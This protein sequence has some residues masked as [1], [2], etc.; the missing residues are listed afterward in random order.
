MIAR[1]VKFRRE[2]NSKYEKGLYFEK[3]QLLLDAQENVM[4]TVYDIIDDITII[5]FSTMLL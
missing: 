1:V 5:D 3:S 2:E 4:C